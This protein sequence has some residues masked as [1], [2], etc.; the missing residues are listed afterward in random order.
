MNKF[1]SI[2]SYAIIVAIMALVGFIGFIEGEE[3]A[4]NE[5][6]VMYEEHKEEVQ[7]LK[8]QIRILS[9]DSLMVTE[10][11]EDT[12]Y[13]EATIMSQEIMPDGTYNVCWC[14]NYSEVQCY[15]TY[16]DEKLNEDIPYLLTMSSNK[17]KTTLD[18]EVV[19]IW[20]VIE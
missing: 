15:V 9:V 19:V 1:F 7:S 2:V 17:T 3:K 16:S 13:G 6:Q 11:V 4:L 20:G 10:K 14:V 18:D 5:I 8:K 12:Y